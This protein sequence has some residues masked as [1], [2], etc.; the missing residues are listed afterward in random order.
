MSAG[1]TQSRDHLHCLQEAEGAM[2]AKR[3]KE[4]HSS[5]DQ[6]KLEWESRVRKDCL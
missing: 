6:N 1:E 5:E 3:E 4:S 2:G